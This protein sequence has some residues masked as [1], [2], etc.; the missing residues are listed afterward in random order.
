MKKD[1]SSRRSFLKKSAILAV[2]LAAAAPAAVIGDD[3]LKSRIARLEDEKA[4]RELHNNW[5]R[6]VNSGVTDAANPLRADRDSAALDQSVRRI[7]AD[8]TAEPDSIN[9]AAD[10][11]TATGKFQCAVDFETP[12]AKDCTL[13]QMAHLQGDGFVRRTE[14]RAL[15]I[16]YVKNAGGAWSIAKAEL[17]TS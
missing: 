12:I 16:E 4:I 6:Q 13:A 2:P 8:H 3:G 17:A 11:K 14:R 9:F 1:A 15:R 5:L 10:G 7:A